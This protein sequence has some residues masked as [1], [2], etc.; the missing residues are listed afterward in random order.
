MSR[1]LLDTSA[2]SALF[3]GYEAIAD[4]TRGADRIA[5][6]PVTLGELE[7]GF[8]GGSRRDKNR[9][10]LQR[11]LESPRVRTVV[12]DAE[13]ADRYAQICDSLR[14]AGTPIPSNDIWIAA[15]AMQFGLRLVSTDA[16][17]E[18]VQQITLELHD[19]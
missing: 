19:V 13:T 9:A 16:H 11:F 5:V 15:S 8:R 3:R 17:F 12:I 4:S 14:R 2:V 7:T 6:S 18:R 10:L 1:L